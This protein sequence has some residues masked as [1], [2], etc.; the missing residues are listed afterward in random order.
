MIKKMLLIIPFLLLTESAFACSCAKVPLESAVKD[1]KYIYIGMIGDNKV[2]LSVPS[3]SHFY[4][5]RRK[6]HSNNP[7][8]VPNLSVSSWVYVI[9]YI[10]GRARGS[11]IKT[12]MY[13]DGVSCRVGA[14]RIGT[15]AVVAA[16]RDGVQAIGSCSKVTRFFRAT[17]MDK[18]AKYVKKLKAIVNKQ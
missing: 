15:I 6:L 9:D 12:A 4:Q 5:Q 14:P 3:F 11:W 7:P 8:R 13:H 1:A 16:Y 2:D 17:E 10:K 18:A